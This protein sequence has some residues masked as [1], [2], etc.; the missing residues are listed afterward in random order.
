MQKDELDFTILKEYWVIIWC[1]AHFMIRM[2]TNMAFTMGLVS[3][4]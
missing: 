3:F 2:L 4:T 1:I